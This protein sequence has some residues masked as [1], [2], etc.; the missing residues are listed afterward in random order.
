MIGLNASRNNCSQSINALTNLS[1]IENEYWI[2]KSESKSA[3]III[4]ESIINGLSFETIVI[5]NLFNGLTTQNVSNNLELQSN[6][7]SSFNE[8]RLIV[9]QLQNGIWKL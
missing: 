9:N 7:N 6:I 3:N 8:Y 5:M 1:Q 4:K 2:S